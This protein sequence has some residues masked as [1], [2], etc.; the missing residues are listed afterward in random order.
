G[1][2]MRLYGETGRRGSA[3]REYQFC[4]A[5]LQRE[6]RTEPE[7]ETKVLYHEILR[8]RART[9][10]DEP[11]QPMHGVRAQPG[12]SR[13]PA[14]EPPAAWEPPLVGRE[15]QVSQLLEALDGAFS[16]RGRF[17]ILVGEAGVGE[18]RPARGPRVAAP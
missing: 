18:A 1:V 10:S 17:A 13:I 15:R 8:Q 2:L 5:M 7:S 11:S 6:L 16:G 9:V 4:V 3:L 14:I 12:S